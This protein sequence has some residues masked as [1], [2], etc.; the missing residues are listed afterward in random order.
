MKKNMMT[1]SVILKNR[2]N[3]PVTYQI[4]DIWVRY[5][6]NLPN[7]M[8]KWGKRIPHYTIFMSILLIHKNIT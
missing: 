6:E 7:F 3:T 5:M 1:L 2:Q 8:N 4:L